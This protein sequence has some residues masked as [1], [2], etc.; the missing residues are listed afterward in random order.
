MKL[1]Y[2]RIKSQIEVILLGA[3]GERAQNI[4]RKTIDFQSTSKKNCYQGEFFSGSLV[5]CHSKTFTN[6][7][8]NT[9]M[10]TMCPFG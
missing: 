8:N 3:D 7:F 5:C 1:S 4:Y 2:F 10:R 9:V 6:L